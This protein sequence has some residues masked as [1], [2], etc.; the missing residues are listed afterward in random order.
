[1]NTVK[2]LLNILKKYIYIKYIYIY[3]INNSISI[4]I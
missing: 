3:L 2:K 4:H 1:M